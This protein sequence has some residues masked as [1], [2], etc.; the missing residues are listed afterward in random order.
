MGTE[1][2]TTPQ[3]MNFF[4]RVMMYMGVLKFPR[5]RMYWNYRT[6]IAVIAD[7]MALN[8][9]FKL[10]AAIPITDETA[11]TLKVPR[12]FGKCAL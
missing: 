8:R 5:I 11:P 10:R 4:F 2:A 1:L 12:S 6:R 9:F 7:A 3:E